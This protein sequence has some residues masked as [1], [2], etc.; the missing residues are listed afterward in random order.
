MPITSVYMYV[1]MYQASHLRFRVVCM[2]ACV[3]RSD[4]DKQR[5]CDQRR[6]T[7]L[8]IWTS[9]A[10][11]FE[12]ES[13]NA[14]LPYEA[15]RSH[16]IPYHTIF[17]G[18]IRIKSKSKSKIKENNQKTVETCYIYSIQYNIRHEERQDIT[19]IAI[20]PYPYPRKSLGTEQN[21]Q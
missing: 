7:A 17:T 14:S 16:T 15:F 11:V 20:S 6:C 1:C 19:P 2:N 9:R 18:R 5:V 12:L 21:S 13:R 10:L 4:D 3:I 8:L